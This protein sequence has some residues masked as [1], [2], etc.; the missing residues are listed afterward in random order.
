MLKDSGTQLMHQP[1]ADLKTAQSTYGWRVAALMV[2]IAL[3]AAWHWSVL[4][5]WF[6]IGVLAAWERSIQTHPLAPLIIIAAYV[7]GGIVLFPVT[8]LTAVTIITFGPVVG[9]L[10]GLAGWL[11][12]ASLGFCV[13]RSVGL[14]WLSRLLGERFERLRCAAEKKGLLAV[15]GLRLVPVAPF[16]IVN[17]FIGASG[18]RFADFILGS[19]LGRIPGILAFTLFAVQLRTLA[20]SISL[21][22]FLLVIVGL[23]LVF[24]GQ[25]WI[26]RQLAAATAALE[27]P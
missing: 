23:T 2:L 13:G 6:D 17:L 27:K 21:G 3:A 10:Y 16:S 7:L 26:T 25:R 19:M 12:S 11:V 24:L 5:G 14:D 9:N 1:I 20:Q 15:L 18:I 22:K 4:N 8:V